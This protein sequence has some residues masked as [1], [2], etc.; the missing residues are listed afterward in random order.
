M[1]FALEA[2]LEW[3]GLL[4]NRAA[5]RRQDGNWKIGR[6]EDWKN[7]GR[8]PN[9]PVMHPSIFPSFHFSISEQIAATQSMRDMRFSGSIFVLL[10]PGPTRL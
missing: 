2:R 8:H 6:L 1:V 10:F 3:V 5:R 4:P 7:G 9:H